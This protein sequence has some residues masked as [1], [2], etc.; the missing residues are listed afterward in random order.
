MYPNNL[1]FVRI[2][3]QSHFFPLLDTPVD[4]Q[5]GFGMLEYTVQE[6]DG[7]V[8]VTVELLVFDREF[9]QVSLTVITGDGS[10][11]GKALIKV[12]SSPMHTHAVCEIVLRGY[13]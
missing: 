12:C 6:S 7:S 13:N 9:P 4:V 1:A 3:I 8:S 11:I 2:G 5:I 10:A